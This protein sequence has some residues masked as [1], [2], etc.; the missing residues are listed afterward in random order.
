MH[1]SPLLFNAS[2][3]LAALLVRFVFIIHISILLF[4]QI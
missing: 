3:T 4:E 1:S 2:W